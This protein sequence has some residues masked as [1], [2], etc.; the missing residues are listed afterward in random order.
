MWVECRCISIDVN[1]KCDYGWIR[2]ISLDPATT[3]ASNGQMPMEIERR[4]KCPQ[5][6]QDNLNYSSIS[7]EQTIYYSTESQAGQQNDNM[8]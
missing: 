5:K 2:S 1:C 6:C 4:W 8:Q 7:A 3:E